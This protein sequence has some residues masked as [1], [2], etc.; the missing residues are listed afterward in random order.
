MSFQNNQ[1][2]I[3]NF[4]FEHPSTILL[5]GPTKSGKTTLLSKI[6]KNCDKGLVCPPPQR[7][8]YCYSVWQ[9]AF[10]EMRSSRK[11]SNEIEF[12]DGL[13]DIADFNPS[14]NSIPI[15]NDL[16][17]QA[18]KDEKVLK[19]FTV[20]SHHLNLTIF[21][22][23][24][25]IFPQEKYSCSISL[26]CQYILLT[27]NPRDRNQLVQLG[28]Q[29]FTGN[30]KFFKEASDDAVTNRKYGYLV[31]ALNQNTDEENRVQTG[32]LPNETRII[33]RKKFRNKIYLKFI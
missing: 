10:E 29:I 4:C 19:L 6:L 25:N 5:S 33:Y 3:D 21:F 23:T 2:F 9:K 18:G 1:I 11:N 28:K 14:Q 30:T 27:K 16:M 20:D 31:L 12:K 15:L 13:P 32:I 17:T 22:F 24:Q 7:I 26:N 8:M